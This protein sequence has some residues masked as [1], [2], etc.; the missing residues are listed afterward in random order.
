[1][2]VTH[3]HDA[4]I[5]GG[6]PAGAAC[7]LWLKLLGLSPVLV[8]KGEQLGGLQN[9]NPFPGDWIPGLPGITGT[10]MAGSIHDH[11]RRLG[12]A[13]LTRCAVTAVARLSQGGWEAQLAGEGPGTVR[14]RFLVL[15]TGVLP[16][17]GG[18]EESASVLIGPGRKVADV[19][20][21]G[22][23]VA[24]LGGGDNA[25]ENFLFARDR[26]ATATRIFARHVRARRDLRRQVPSDAIS[27]PAYRADAKTMRVN[28][29]PFD[30][31]L[32]LYG[33]EPVNP[34]GKQLGLVT[35]EKGF[36]RSDE[37]RRTSDPDVYAI[38]ELA[39]KLHPCVATSVAD[40][41]VCAKDIQSR[42]ETAA[43][44]GPAGK[45]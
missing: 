30:V 33:W 13:T 39:Q 9:C 38:G 36:V 14:A 5:A 22:K 27:G 26:G 37:R 7:A 17:T 15:A 19:D 6:G 45:D 1:M 24:I 2:A 21:R 32:V 40:G 29:E 41:I 34:V 20:F 28:G 23:R 4:L 31:F 42:L 44:N 12:V 43:D 25:F 35:D 10:A 11:V 3:W 18:L 16:V 8:E